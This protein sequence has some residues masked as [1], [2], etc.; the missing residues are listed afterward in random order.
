MNDG[1]LQDAAAGLAWLAPSAPSLAA[2]AAPSTAWS[3]LRHD[4]AAIL[5]LARHDFGSFPH[6]SLVSPEPV[7][8]ALARLAE[9]PSGLAGWSEPLRPLYEPAWAL[10]RIASALASR[11]GRASPLHAWSAG[12]LAPLGWLAVA[13]ACPDRA[14]DC[15][16]DPNLPRDVTRAQE[17]HWGVTAA[18]LTRRLARSWGLPSWLQESL[19]RIEIPAPA[20]ARLGGDPSLLAI[21]RVATHLAA[22]AGLDPCLLPRGESFEED[23]AWLGL[24]LSGLDPDELLRDARLDIP[25][26]Q[27]PYQ[28]PLLPQMLTLA[29]ENR[30]LLGGAQ[31]LRLE[32]EADALHSALR[33]QV[34]GEAERL[35][36]AKLTALAELAAGA[37][38]EINN[39]LTVISG[40]AQYVLSHGEEWLSGDEEGAARKAL[41]VII[42]Q[43][44]RVHAILRDLMLFARPAP[45]RP[46]VFDLPTLLGEVAASLGEM[47]ASKGVRV[48]VRGPDRLAAWADVE[49][50]RQALT[51]LARN[52]VEAAP[53]GGW[54]RL[55]ALASPDGVEASVEDSGPG[56]AAEQVPHLFDPFFSGRNAG[57]GKGLGL[58]V[59]WRLARQQG[60]DVRFEPPRPG[61][62]TRFVLSLPSPATDGLRAA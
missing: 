14:L 22:V 35:R 11:T 31:R 48:E 2:L 54:A 7:R 36:Q 47:A 5:L 24:T 3:A 42:A 44:K 46:T 43:T 39:P 59:A 49:Q 15:W 38:H 32:R 33:D 52:A 37:G 41:G 55:T 12:L 28:A 6:G 17:R 40:Q 18:G 25:A 23:A 29:A 53:S 27:S 51:C 56:P 58:P 21:V 19:G 20:A 34:Q 26:W 13:A 45:A 1:T 61:Q 10:A 50:T 60:G 4:P 62:P 8:L 16:T 30:A 57:R 9:P